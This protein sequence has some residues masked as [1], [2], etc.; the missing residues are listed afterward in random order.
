MGDPGQISSLLGPWSPHLLN[1][2]THL[3]DRVFLARTKFKMHIQN[4]DGGTLR[5][6]M[7]FIPVA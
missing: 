1:V 5:N 2:N 6:F 4:Q 3:D 7:Y